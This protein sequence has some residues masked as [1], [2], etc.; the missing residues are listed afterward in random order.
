MIRIRVQP[1]DFD[2]GAELAALPGDI[3]GVGAV[4][5]FVGIVRGGGGLF[6]LTLEHYP[7]MSEAALGAIAAQADARWP[8]T[9]I[10]IVHRVGRLISGDRIVL[11]AAASGHRAAAL[12]A[13][14]FL[15]DQLKSRAPF[16]KREEGTFGHRWVEGTLTDEAA[17]TARWAASPPDSAR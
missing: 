13:V 6:A 15:M 8:L 16:W 14:A 2:I 10:V 12:E 3:P 11:V 1:E 17:A 9:A 4:A 5:S 7:G